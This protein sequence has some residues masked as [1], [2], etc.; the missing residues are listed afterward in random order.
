MASKRVGKHNQSPFRV[1]VV[2]DDHQDA[3]FVTS[4]LE[5]AGVTATDVVTSG[6]DALAMIQEGRHDL[7]ILDLNLPGITGRDVLRSVRGGERNSN[8]PIIVLSASAQR[9]D[10]EECYGLRA[11]AYI[12]KPYGIEEYDRIAQGVCDFWKD[13]SLLPDPAPAT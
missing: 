5:E 3:F 4:A 1:L 10:I 8:T 11:N 12:V 6:A 2:D 9:T 13:I 7:V